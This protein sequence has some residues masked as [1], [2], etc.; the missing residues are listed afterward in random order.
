MPATYTPISSTTISGSSTSTVTI[1]N[2]PST[3]TDLVVVFGNFQGTT[4]YSFSLRFNGDTGSNYVYVNLEGNGTTV[5]ATNNSGTT[6][7][8]TGG[9]IGFPDN[10]SSAIFNIS[11]YSNTF[12]YKPVVGRANY[13]G[14]GLAGVNITGG[15]WN[16]TAAITSITTFLASGNFTA[17]GE[18]TL[19][20]IKKA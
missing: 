7:I 14:T 10:K 9:V 13:N 18:I 11:G 16:S 17:G 19:Y 12:G 20:G 2:I 3:F 8:F 4:S 15:T 5:T 1:S 6:G